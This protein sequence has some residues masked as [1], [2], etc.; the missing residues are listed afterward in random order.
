MSINGTIDVD[1]SIMVSYISRPNVLFSEKPLTA[2]KLHIH[3]V[4][5]L[6]QIVKLSSDHL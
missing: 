5:L 2:E 4:L 1:I 6:V 3:S